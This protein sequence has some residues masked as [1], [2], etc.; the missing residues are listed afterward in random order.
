MNIISMSEVIRAHNGY[1]FSKDTMRFFN[2][3]LPQSA[4]EKDGLAYFVT[5]EKFNHETARKY[6]I[7]K[8][9][10]KTGGINTVGDF[11]AYNSRAKAMAGIKNLLIE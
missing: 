4:Y 9:D 6:T 11:Q 7:R 1:F 8:C 5:S 3:R 10:L 2:S